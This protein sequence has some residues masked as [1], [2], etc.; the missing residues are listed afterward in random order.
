MTDEIKQTQLGKIMQFQRGYDLTHSEMS[1]GSI[2][3]VGSSSVIGYHDKIKK[4]GPAL[5]IG[6]SGT[7]G[8][9]QYFDQDIWPHNTTLF[10]RDYLG[11]D[12]KFCFYLLKALNLESYSTSTG[13]PTLNRNFIHPL[14]VPKIEVNSQRQIAEPCHHSI[15]KSS[16][17]AKSTQS[18]S[19]R[20]V[21]YMIIGLSSSTSQIVKVNPTNPPADK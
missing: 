3:V 12:P 18:W 21:R 9:P 4:T 1:G 6:R 16:S 19:R 2:P 7:V 17:I 5:L 10:V 14:K 11:N 20:H 8:R 15:T 13:V